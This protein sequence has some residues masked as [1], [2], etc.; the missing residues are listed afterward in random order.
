LFAVKEPT[1]CRIDYADS[2]GLWLGDNMRTARMSHVCSDCGRTI[3]AGERYHYARWIY[4]GDFYDAKLCD[5]CEAAAR[6][7][8]LVCGGWL[9]TQIGEELREHV[10]EEGWPIVT[11]GLRWLA[12]MHRRGWKRKSGALANVDFVRSVAERYGQQTKDAIAE[13]VLARAA[14]RSGEGTEPG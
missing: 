11:R 4:D 14:A 9:W 6:W 2:D 8:T 10:D 7:L 1:M 3:E 5:R 12:E 13:R